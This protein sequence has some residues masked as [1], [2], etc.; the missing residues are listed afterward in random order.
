MKA[1]VSASLVVTVFCA[2]AGARAQSHDNGSSAGIDTT[3]HI[4]AGKSYAAGPTWRF[5]FGSTWRDV[6][7]TPVEAPVLDLAHFGHGLT[8]FKQGGN[9]SLTLHFHGADGRHYVFRT[10]VKRIPANFRKDLQDTPVGGVVIDQQSATHPAGALIADVLQRAAGILHAP[11]QLVVMPNDP[12]LGEYR[13]DFGGKL[14]YVELKPEDSDGE[15]FAG[16]KKIRDSDHMVQ[17]LDKSLATRLDA[18]AWLKA[19]LFDAVVG[20][21]D[22]GADNWDWACYDEGHVQTCKPIARDRDWAFL[23]S[24]GLMMRG[25]RMA[26]PRLG[27]YDRTGDNVKSVTAMT[28]EFDRTRLVGLS[29]QDWDNVVAE[30]RA[31]LSDAVIDSALRAQPAS[32]RSLEDTKLI[33]DGIRARRNSLPAL[34]ADYFALVNSYANVF[35]ADDD[36]QADIDRLPNG[37]V[38][39]RIAPS[40]DGA[41]SVV[42]DRT[43]RRSETKEIRVFLE[44]GDDRAV[45]RGKAANSIL[46]RV[47]GGAGDDV[48]ADSSSGGRTYFYDAHGHNRIVKGH[49]TDV[50]ERSYATVQP[51]TLESREDSTKREHRKVQEERPGRF[52]DQRTDAFEV[53][54]PNGPNL[55]HDWGAKTSFHPS[56]D[57]HQGSSVIL[58][59]GLSNTRYGFRRDPY[60]SHLSAKLTYAPLAPTPGWGLEL[61]AQWFAPNSN[62]S[63]IVE[64]RGA[65]YDIQHF[66]GY[67]NASPTVADS[68]VRIQRD[69]V[70][71]N[72]ASQW[73]L[74]SNAT[75]TFGPTFR[76]VKPD[77]PG[78][79]PLPADSKERDPFSA[80]G[81]RAQFDYMR[82]DDPV[83]LHRGL[84]ANFTATEYGHALD[85]TGAFGRAEGT[86]QTYIPIGQPT[87]ALQVVGQR[88]W[89]PFPIHEAAIIGGRHTMRGFPFGRYTGDAA[90]SGAA[91]L[92]IPLFRM[93]LLTKGRLGL[94]GLA[95]AGRVWMDGV[96]DGSLHKS[97]GGGLSFTTVSR[98]ATATYAHG[99]VNRFY[100]RLGFPF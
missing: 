78:T 67:G 84:H 46:V 9:Q 38:R 82:V 99:D 57:Y 43:F 97:F 8:P 36:D 55:P 21:F 22:R 53:V 60:A 63:T 20:D 2:A 32:Y 19:R 96:S 28:H 50:D 64:L 23:R 3:A 69:E 74:G 81:A 58:G 41:G 4:V 37:D 77:V 44:E 25:V 31:N 80:V 47:I 15:V 30:L 87:L 7:T 90:L 65:Q 91:E 94:I 52:E 76:Y 93:T 12:K 34:A 10:V 100:L 79:V 85:A 68:F 89:G 49:D 39:V 59:V 13:K 51:G 83:L 18:R 75:F 5:F 27:S 35:A 56:V 66:F 92:R 62:R 86:V 16:A 54:K 45:V 29:K 6:W 98:V 14:G 88:A 11:P 24:D 95:D 17:A 72:I 1:I 48:L 42:F 73:Q 70:L 71:A 40:G 61:G 26:F 33:R